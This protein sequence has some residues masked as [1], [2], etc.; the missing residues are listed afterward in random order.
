MRKKPKEGGG[1]GRGSTCG[2]RWCRYGVAK[3]SFV[4]LRE[5]STRAKEAKEGAKP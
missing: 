1:E 3:R 5:G 4:K 2:E